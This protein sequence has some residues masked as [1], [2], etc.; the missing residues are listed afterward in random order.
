MRDIRYSRTF[1]DDLATLL[2]QGID[3]FGGK[4]VAEKRD[5]VFTTIA[6]FLAHHPAAKRPH[7]TLGL[8]VYPISKTPFVVLYDFDDNELRVHFI[9]H[10]HADLT[11]LD[12][13][14]VEW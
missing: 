11:A 12:P 5:L 7:P 10:K 6:T 8:R 2:E 4:V 9:L 3:R 1:Y 14:S 13:T